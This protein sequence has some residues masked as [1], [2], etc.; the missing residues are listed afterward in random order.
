MI[1][2]RDVLTMVVRDRPASWSLSRLVQRS[3][4]FRAVAPPG[5]TTQSASQLAGEDRARRRCACFE[6]CHRVARPP[7]SRHVKVRLGA[8]ISIPRASSDDR[9]R[10]WLIKQ[11][12]WNPHAHLTPYSVFLQEGGHAGRTPI[13]AGVHASAISRAE[14]RQSGSV[15]WALPPAQLPT[16]AETRLGGLMRTFKDALTTCAISRR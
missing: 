7:R 8:V 11:R 13:G 3:S 9:S 16:A 5:A 14:G 4:S 12:R 6:T 1:S 2:L 15:T 10:K